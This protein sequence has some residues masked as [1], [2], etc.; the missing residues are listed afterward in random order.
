MQLTDD[1]EAFR[2]A[3]DWK[4][5]HTLK[6]ILVSLN[7]EASELL[8]LA[9]WKT[10]A[11]LAEFAKSGPGRKAIAE[12][13][14]DIFIYLLLISRECGVDLIQATRTKLS[15]NAQKYPVDKSHGSAKK[16]TEL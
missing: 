16:Y 8:E 14:A 4:Q 1:I 15:K 6:N 11:E 7:L 3:R 12:E 10:D 5:F 9:Q 2:D 13:C